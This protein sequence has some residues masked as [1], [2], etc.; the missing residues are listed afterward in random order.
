MIL[1][2][3]LQ[4]T[5]RDKHVTHTDV[6]WCVYSKALDQTVKSNLL[7]TTRDQF[8]CKDFF[9]SFLHGLRLTDPQPLESSSGNQ[10][11]TVHDERITR[12]RQD[13]WH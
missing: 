13:H 7:E 8:S 3:Q 1:L 11:R 9:I 2:K 4:Q 12:S 5:F 6:M 10:L